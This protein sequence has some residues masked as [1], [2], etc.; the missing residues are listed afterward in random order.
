MA[1]MK[2]LLAAALIG[3]VSAAKECKYGSCT[4]MNGP[5]FQTGDKW[6]D[7]AL[8][9]TRPNA[10]KQPGPFDKCSCTDK[11]EAAPGGYTGAYS[12][13]C[14]GRLED[15]GAAPG[16]A[17]TAAGVP[18]T[19]TKIYEKGQGA[20]AEKC[21]SRCNATV[22]CGGFIF[23]YCKKFYPF[24]GAPSHV[25]PGPS[26]YPQTPFS[27]LLKRLLNAFSHFPPHP[28]SHPVRP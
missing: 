16:P 25:A 2:L 13:T 11:Y 6:G 26:L 21:A 28:P 22:G 9:K 19:K 3:T 18:G 7:L 5:Q 27:H 10:G 15:Q 8:L 17:Y 24:D 1:N 20:T 23:N 12:V 14:A 4:Y